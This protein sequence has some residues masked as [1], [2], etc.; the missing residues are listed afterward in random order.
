MEEK[1]PNPQPTPQA[2]ESNQ[3]HTPEHKTSGV[4]SKLPWI[5][6][7]LLL[8]L[9]GF[10]GGFFILS[11]SQKDQGQAPSPVPSASNDQTQTIASPTTAPTS[12][13]KLESF[14]SAKLTDLSFKGY[15]LMYPSDWSLSEK[16]DES[17]SLST[18][19][20]TKNGYTLKIYQAATG[21]AGCV[22]EGDMPEGPASD[23]RNNK[24]KDL[25]TGFATLRQTE[26]L[27]NGKISYNYCQKSET[28]DSYGQPTSVGHMS[29]STQVANPDTVI[30]DEFEKIIES[31]KTL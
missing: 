4:K 3:T 15:T 8:V 22:Y 12:S 7:A 26:S 5:L 19:T 2:H 28:G 13:T 1:N 16:K 27:N 20:L 21:G 18:V 30:V 11:Q 17:L 10:F 23:Y 25:K 9:V 31:I 14:T 24:Y 6:V 29:I